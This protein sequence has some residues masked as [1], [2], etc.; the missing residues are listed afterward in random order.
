MI[1]FRPYPVMTIAAVA[2]L[3]VLV[4]LGNWQMKRLAW[5]TNLIAQAEASMSAAPIPFD[6]V[7]S[8]STE[9]PA[10][11]EYIQVHLRGHFDHSREMHVFGQALDGMPG[12]YI[13]TPLLREG[14]EPVIVNR[15][16]VPPALR[17]PVLRHEGQVLGDIQVVGLIRHSRTARPFQPR[18]DPN[19]G[20]WFVAN[21]DE[22]AAAAPLLNVAPVFVD[23]GS[24]P[25]PGGWPLGG[26]TRL[27]FRNSHLGYA[28]TWYGLAAALFAVYIAV[29]IGSGRLAIRRSNT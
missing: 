29:H 14:M 12:Y 23:A 13:Y 20:D 27:Q 17:D 19:S 4:L 28:L 26:Q 2:A 9:T 3:I 22:M 25:N 15:G 8:R 1:F 21:L 10:N 16:F 5:K 11:G 6:E 24:A 7:I 18:N